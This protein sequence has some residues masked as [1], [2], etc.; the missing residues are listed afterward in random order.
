MDYAEAHEGYSGNTG[1]FS[2]SAKTKEMIEEEVREL[3]EEGYQEAR[4]ILIEKE[5]QFER[6]AKGLL[7]YETLTGEEIGKVI[8]GEPLGGDDDTPS[9]AIPAVP[10][11]PRIPPASGGPAPVPTA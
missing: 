8:R 2:V 6:L 4:R 1:G 10:A 5:E 7:E 3:I 11:V 9:S